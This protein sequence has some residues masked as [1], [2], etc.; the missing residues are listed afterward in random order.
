[1]ATLDEQLM[2]LLAS[3]P[4]AISQGLAQSQNGGFN[5]GGWNFNPLNV[6]IPGKTVLGESDSG[7]QYS[8]VYDIQDRNLLQSAGGSIDPNTGIVSIG[9]QQMSAEDFAKR[10]AIA[11]QE[12]SG[13]TGLGATDWQQRLVDSQTGKILGSDAYKT[14]GFNFLK[15]IVLPA[16]TIWGGG[17]LLGGALGA[18]A[19][20]GAAA[21]GGGAASGAAGTLGASYVPTVVSA[22]AAAPL[23]G[24]M[25]AIAAGLPTL[26]TLGA[27][28]GAAGLG[29]SYVPTAVSAGSAA[30]LTGGMSQV[31]AGLPS[32]SKIGGGLLGSVGSAL[33]G[34]AD[35]V[36]GG[37]NL[38]GIVGGLLGASQGG[39]DQQATSQQQIDPRM[40]QYLY[41]TGVGDPN[42]YLGAAQQLWQDN[43]SGI[44]PVM[45]E[46]MD[47]Q[48][49]ALRDP[50]YAQSY[51][52]MQTAGSGLLGGGVAANPFTTGQASL[53]QQPMSQAGGGLLGDSDAIRRL[54]QSGRGLIPGGVQ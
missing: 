48:L 9:G 45:Q 16:A 25:G 10:Y 31:A 24:G 14:E 4:Q 29:A 43:K 42:S 1:M 7:P 2:A 41:G 37:K 11:Q 36:G 27:G 34:V 21:G 35:L 50:A 8:S 3:N 30:P 40:Q 5:R 22:G 17:A 52:Q 46:G 38:A 18:G 26:P 13:E 39:K 23:T 28:L 20:A 32:V 33:G 51:R 47:M 49:A 54:I 15:D 19:G 53:G 44:N 12:M 6:T